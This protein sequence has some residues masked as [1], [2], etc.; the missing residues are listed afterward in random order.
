VPESIK[1]TVKKDSQSASFDWIYP[2]YLTSPPFC[3]A[4]RICL[5]VAETKTM[6]AMAQNINLHFIFKQIN[7]NKF[8]LNINS[9]IFRRNFY[10]GPAHVTLL[11]LIVLIIFAE[12][13][14]F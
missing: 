4:T 12:A 8:N 3:I 2:P 13:V 6:I 5:L 7:S 9:K 11:D 10:I 14:S 1:S